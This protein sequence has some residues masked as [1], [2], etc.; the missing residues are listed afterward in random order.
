MA[1]ILPR[2]YIIGIIMF[3]FLIVGGL[4]LLA[5]YNSYDETYIDQTKYA[6][7]NSTFNTYNDINE[8]VGGL[9]AGI[10]DAEPGQ[11]YGTLGVLEALISSGWNTLQLM[12]QSFGFMNDVFDGLSDVFGIPAWVGVLIT[13]IITT[14][15]VFAIYAA[16]F[17]R[18]L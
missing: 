18:E 4:A 15:L 17:Q 8:Q 6:E 13:L 7:F 11:D 9:Q 14:I 3:T 1:D 10:E 2:H 5:E 16:I 12:F